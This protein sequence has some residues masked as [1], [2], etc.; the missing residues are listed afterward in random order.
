M[1][2]RDR[3]RQLVSRPDEA[4]PLAETALWIAAEAKPDLDVGH[5]LDAIDRLADQVRNAIAGANGDEERIARLNHA[6]FVEAGFEGNRE[7]YDD[8]RNSFLD[9]VLDRRI[10]IPITLSVVYIE[11][12]RKVGFDAQ[13]IGFPGHFLS[14]ITTRR[15]V[16]VVDPFFGSTMDMAACERRLRDVAGPGVRFDPAMLA[17]SPHAAIL[18]RILTNLRQIY[19]ARRD[20]EAAL[21]CSDRI[22]IVAPGH[23]AEYRD[24]ALIHRELECFGAALEDFDRYLELAP[25]EAVDPAIGVILAELRDKAAH[26]H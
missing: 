10:G 21:A 5:Y 19:I 25:I 20:F 16:V 26:V 7:D 22:L 4:I 17:S 18:Q 13:G 24:R 9:V 23:I 6:L 2:P 1:N 8:P 15:G 3:F 12:A 11:V 14:K